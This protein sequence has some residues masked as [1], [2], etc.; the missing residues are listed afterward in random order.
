MTIKQI[1]R[2][3]VWEEV[4]EELQRLIASGHWEKG[5]KLP[6]EVELAK[7]FGVSRSAL[8]EALRSLSSMGLV[9]IRHGEGNFVWYPEAEDYL[10]SLVARLMVDREDV[11]AI[12][13]ARSMVEV[14][15]AMLAAE[16]VTPELLS[17]M[18]LLLEKMEASS[19]DRERFARYDH[20][21]HKQIALATQN[22]V[23]VK[24]YEAIEVFLVSQQLKIVF[25]LDAIERGIKDHRAILS[26]IKAGDGELAAEAMNA[27]M[28]STY[29][30][31]LENT[32]KEELH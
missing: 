15:T 31:I 10:N 24:I 26:A 18:E 21:F 12:M 9:Q 22:S 11:L 6:S 5:E 32:G 7:E 27:H 25:Y 1:R 28:E 4:A 30:A 13:E 8:R 19:D 29:R 23:I 2:K 20:R 16:R 14:K 3:K 17:E